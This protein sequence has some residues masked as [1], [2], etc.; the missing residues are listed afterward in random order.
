MIVRII[1]KKGRNRSKSEKAGEFLDEEDLA[2]GKQE[3]DFPQILQQIVRQQRLENRGNFD[4]FQRLQMLSLNRAQN[5][6]LKRLAG[7]DFNEQASFEKWDDDE[8]ER[9]EEDLDAYPLRLKMLSW[10]NQQRN[11]SWSDGLDHTRF[12]LK[13]FS[14]KEYTGVS[15]EDVSA[16]INVC[17]KRAV[18]DPLRRFLQRMLPKSMVAHH[19]AQQKVRNFERHEGIPA[20]DLP[21]LRE[22]ISPFVDWLG[23]LFVAIL[24][25]T[26]FL[27]PIIVMNLAHD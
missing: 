11:V 8:W 3:I 10:K 14:D 26:L 17:P 5:W 20:S 21:P 9:M 15:A 25:G 6:L 27:L 23:R 7:S 16:F 13:S 1:D 4:T 18:E 22:D 2:V 12:M 19:T 24:A